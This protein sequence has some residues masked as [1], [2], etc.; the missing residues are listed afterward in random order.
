MSN[1]KSNRFIVKKR[2]LNPEYAKNFKAS[3]KSSKKHLQRG[4]TPYFCTNRLDSPLAFAGKTTDKRS[5]IFMGFEWET[6]CKHAI[7][8]A[9]ELIDH[10]TLCKYVHLTSEH[11]GDFEMISSPCT[12]EK[13]K[14]L[15]EK[16]KTLSIAKNIEESHD[17]LSHNI[18]LHIHID[19]R[20]FSPVS[21]RKFL[22]FLHNLEDN[23]D[24]MNDIANREY[25]RKDKE[26]KYVPYIKTQY[27]TLPSNDFLNVFIQRD[28]NNQLKDH[29]EYMFK[30]NINKARSFEFIDPRERECFKSSRAFVKERYVAIRKYTIE[31]RFFGSCTYIEQLKVMLE[32]CDALTRYVRR[33]KVQNLTAKAFCDYVLKDEKSYPLLAKST[34][35]LNEIERKENNVNQYKTQKIRAT[36]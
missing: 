11:V 4:L 34:A 27:N 2:K 1:K 8:S 29:K 13:H 24:F 25:C 7:E 23:G 20:A 17:F 12:L 26:D 30:K 16:M 15:L 18:G 28:I 5:K 33:V 14:E 22:M 32:F 3:L 31:L 21:L 19:A 10:P 35:V 6:Y 9:K 36:K